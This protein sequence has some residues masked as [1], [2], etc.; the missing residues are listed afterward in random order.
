MNGYERIMDALAFKSTFPPPKMLHNFIIAAEY[1]GHTMREY[2]DDPRVIADTHIKFAREFR[3]DGIL[4]DIDTCL[5]A[6]AIGV[7][8]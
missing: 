3:M 7:K 4:L 2:R 6:D 1:A 5:E 8:V